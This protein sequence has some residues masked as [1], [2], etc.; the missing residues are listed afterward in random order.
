MLDELEFEPAAA[1]THIGVVV[2]SG[3]AA[4]W[5]VMQTLTAVRRV[6]GVQAVADE[7][8]GNLRVT[9]TEVAAIIAPS[10]GDARCS[11]NSL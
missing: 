2:E 4:L 6:N 9:E 11:R 3:V 10:F 7:I 8:N 5:G 1:A